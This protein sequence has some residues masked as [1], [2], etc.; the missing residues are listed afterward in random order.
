M[1]LT[2]VVVK[3]AKAAAKPYKMAMAAVCFS[4]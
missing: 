2:D 4:G 3:K 1:L